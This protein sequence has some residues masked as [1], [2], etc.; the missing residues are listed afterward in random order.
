[1]RNGV[2][3]SKKIISVVLQFGFGIFLGHVFFTFYENINC[4]NIITNSDDYD[5]SMDHVSFNSTFSSEPSSNDL[6]AKAEFLDGE[7]IGDE[8][9]RL[10]EKFSNGIQTSNDAI[11]SGNFTSLSK[12]R[13]LLLVGVMTSNRF[14]RTRACTVYN[15]WAKHIHVSQ[16]LLCYKKLFSQLALYS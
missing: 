3:S 1:M 2:H 14:L 10:E 6:E 5:S 13:D 4:D 11:Y 8:T 9:V 12:S 16:F 15:T 7:G